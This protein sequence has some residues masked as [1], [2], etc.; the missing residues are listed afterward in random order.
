LSSG[1]KLVIDNSVTVIGECA[2]T[3]CKNLTSV[4]TGDG[5]RILSH[6][7]FFDCD[8][9]SSVTLGKNVETIDNQAFG[10]CEALQSLYIP[11]S[12]TQISELAFVADCV[13]LSYISVDA[14]NLVYTSIDGNLYSKDGKTLIV[15]APGKVATSFVV[16]EQV[17]S[18][19]SN[20]FASTS[21]ASITIHA[22]VTIIHARMFDYS[23]SLEAI[24]ISPDSVYY[25]SIEGNI[26]TYDGASIVYYAPGKSD[27]SF[28]IP[29]GAT[30][31]C[32]NSFMNAKRLTS[33]EIPNSITEINYYAFCD[34]TSLKTIIYE[35]TMDEWNAIVKGSYWHYNTPIAEIQCSDGVV[36]LD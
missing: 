26:Y 8:N 16:P 3:H 33:I 12:V 2:F 22:G 36:S 1:V 32:T 20:V 6:C 34:C 35:G 15:Y 29:E 31:I 25:K 21:L 10:Y 17:T 19:G 28:K 4:E 7:A 9:L 24:N 27:E 30:T 11:D 5:V 23:N 14:N 13:S 18:L